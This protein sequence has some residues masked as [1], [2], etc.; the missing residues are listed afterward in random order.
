MA[1]PYTAPLT[2]GETSAR[3]RQVVTVEPSVDA[4]RGWKAAASAAALCAVAVA[5]AGCGSAGCGS[6]GSASAPAAGTPATP[7][8]PVRLPAA[9]AACQ[10]WAGLNDLYSETTW[11]R[12]MIGDVVL[13]G[14]DTAQA[15]RDSSAVV[16]YARSLGRIS[17][18]R[19]ARYARE[20]RSS[21]LPVADKPA[22]QTPE[23]LNAAANEAQSLQQRIGS[24][25]F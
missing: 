9:A 1:G 17:A 6:G 12:Q 14:A 25:C 4:M 22:G 7:A 23:Q 10:Q 20:L 13:S 2:P 18:T 5:V 16:L 15:K 8:L 3:R 21:V 19:P 11:L 24:L